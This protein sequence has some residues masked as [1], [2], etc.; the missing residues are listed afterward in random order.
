MATVAI[1]SS[2]LQQV[3]FCYVVKQTQDVVIVILHRKHHTLRIYRI[4]RIVLKINLDYFVSL[5]SIKLYLPKDVSLCIT[6]LTAFDYCRW[7]SPKSIQNN[8]VQSVQS[9][10]KEY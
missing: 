5:R 7:L 9:K 6:F 8:T 1:M 4:Y 3:V 2:V 10:E